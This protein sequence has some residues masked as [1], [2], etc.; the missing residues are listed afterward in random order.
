MIVRYHY[1]K[2]KPVT[3][4]ETGIF[5]WKRLEHNLQ[6]CLDL[7]N[8]RAGHRTAA[9]DEENILLTWERRKIEAGNQSQGVCVRRLFCS[10]A[11]EIAFD[12]TTRVVEVLG[13]NKDNNVFLQESR[14]FM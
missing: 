1:P 9:I 4:Y 5:G 13:R 2:G 6:G 3:T 12:R 10:F 7:S 8:A 11:W 14:G